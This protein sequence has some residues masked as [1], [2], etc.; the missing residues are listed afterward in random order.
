MGIPTTKINPGDTFVNL[1]VVERIILPGKTK[2]GRVRYRCICYCGKERLVEGFKLNDNP[3]MSCG[4]HKSEK[5][6]E[7]GRKRIRHGQARGSGGHSPEHRTWVSMNFRCYSPKCQDWERYG[8]R[9]IKVCKRWRYSFANFFADMGKRPGRGY[10]IDRKDN[11]GDYEPKNCRW[12]TVRESNR[13]KSDTRYLTINGVT[14]SMGH[15]SDETKRGIVT[16][17]Q[18]L[19]RGWSAKRAVFGKNKQPQKILI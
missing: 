8:G 18:R 7:N 17:R 10:V 9:G 2:E 12:L 1:T 4:N 13:N 5:A 11:D 19:N 6:K 14:K 15:W 16:I 3:R